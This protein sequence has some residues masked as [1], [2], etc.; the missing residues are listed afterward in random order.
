MAIE[1]HNEVK[2]LSKGSRIG[3]RMDVKMTCFLKRLE[4]FVGFVL[5]HTFNKNIYYIF[6]IC[7]I[8]FRAYVMRGHLVF[9]M[10]WMNKLI[11]F[12]ISLQ[13]AINPMILSNG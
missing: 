6:R 2:G 7:F 11:R 1:V 3:V 5:F 10:I 13:L 12:A 9:W 4:M 8:Q